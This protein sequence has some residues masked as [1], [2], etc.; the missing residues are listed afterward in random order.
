MKSAVGSEVN[1]AGRQESLARYGLS[2][3]DAWTVVDPEL[4]EM[5]V[6]AQRLLG[7][8][9]CAINILDDGQQYSIA[10]SPGVPLS[11]S[12][13]SL[14]LCHR[15]LSFTRGAEVFATSDASKDPRL[16]DSP[17]VN[18]E[19]TN[20]RFYAAAPLVGR[21]GHPLGTVCMWSEQPWEATQEQLTTLSQ[22]R[23]SVIA[24][25]DS[26]RRAKELAFG[27]CSVGVPSSVH[28]LEQARSP[29]RQSHSSAWTIHRVIDS[30][31]VTTLFQP[32]VSL[33]TGHVVGFEALSRGPQGSDLES[34]MALLSAARDAG[35][36]GELDWLCRS[37]A[38]RAAVAADLHPSL[39]WLINVEPAGLAIE[40]PEHLR[41]VQSKAQTDM[42]VIL[43][44]VERD[45]GGYVTELLHATD[46]ARRD[47][48][49]VALDD[50]GAEEDSLALL[51]FLRPDVVKLDMS[52]VRGVPRA[53]AADITA[54]VRAY[55]E[56]TGAV[57]LAEGIETEEHERLALVF[58]ATY[59]QGYRFGR[60]GS[61]PASVPM[62]RD[63][64]PLRQQLAPLA[65]RTPFEI[66]AGLIEPHRAGKAHL[67]HISEHLEQQSARGALSSVLLAAFQDRK[68]FSD[69]KRWR[70][71]ELSQSNALTVVVAKDLDVHSEARYQTL[72]LSSGS[73]LGGE[74]VVIVINP[75]YAAA[76]VAKDCGDSGADH[77]RRFDYIYTHDRDAVIAAARCYLQELKPS[78]G[79]SAHDNE[80]SLGAAVGF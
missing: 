19:V 68:Y 44:V 7:A 41:E 50:V 62:P 42:R 16:A 51:P 24:M 73:R 17:W 27:T 75:Y 77:E 13:R 45:V 78:L 56:R 26:R 80:R 30:E 8:D 48:W 6:L 67:L 46:Q 66:L 37:Q 76:F 53:E 20:I 4:A 14:S 71:R 58:G 11:V 60:P 1:E 47:S 43:E 54:A 61:L 52:L 33:G 18:G 36:L 40:C 72:P 64:I 29:S 25:L 74:W 9:F 31:A 69:A 12:A 34:P 59:G 22:I 3:S 39:S 49:G 55:A 23:D 79:L 21:E 65:G 2:G 38:M 57:I 5:A 10:G 70:Y 15:I 63:V 32:V 28:L 35:R